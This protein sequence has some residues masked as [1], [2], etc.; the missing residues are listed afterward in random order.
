MDIREYI[1]LNQAVRRWRKLA[2]LSVPAGAAG[3]S[4]AVFF[5]LK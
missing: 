4:L 5:W 2:M 1:L 3:W